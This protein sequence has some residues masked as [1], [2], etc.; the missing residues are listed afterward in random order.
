VVATLN[1]IYNSGIQNGLEY[2]AKVGIDRREEVYASIA[3]GG[4]SRGMTPLQMAAAYTVFA[5]KGV[6]SEP[7]FYTQVLDYSGK[8]ILNNVP[9]HKEVYAPETIYIMDSFLNDVVTKG[10]AYPF[11]IVNY[12]AM[13]KD[14]N[15]KEKEVTVTIPSGGKTGTTDENKDKWF[16]GFTPYYVGAAWYGYDTAVKLTTE[17][18][19]MALNIWSKV[20]LQVHDG[21]PSKPFFEKMP[22][23]ITKIA[24]CLD[25][26]LPPNEF[27]AKDPRGTRVRTELF[28]KGTEPKGVEVCNVHYL[29]HITK[30]EVDAQGRPL[31]ANEFC[32]PDTVEDRVCIRRPVEYKP[33]F[34][35]DKYPEDTKYEAA[36]GEYCTLHGP[37]TGVPAPSVTDGAIILDPNA[38]VPETSPAPEASPLA[39]PS[40]APS[41]AP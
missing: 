18:R 10:T 4:F 35:E 40:P 32:P 19:N 21:L 25:S 33:L 1:L 30:L 22:D 8:L 14:K 11:G 37:G 2:L 5:N 17:E 27:C 12:K 36:E 26:G 13:A 41:P 39:S 15:G 16:C 20:M 3:M 31:F 6:F 28:I 7:M 24:I 34:P 23:N 9:V 29:A 38:P